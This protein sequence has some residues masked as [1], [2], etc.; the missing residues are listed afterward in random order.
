M[1][2]D[3]TPQP[4]SLIEIFIEKFNLPEMVAGPAGKAIS[5]LIAGGA[6]IPAAYLERFA[7]G[8]RDGTAARTKV[9]SEVAEAAAK[10]A[11]G[12]EG[13][14]A[15]A[16]HTLL[17]KE[18][19]RQKNKEEVARKT[20]EILEEETKLI[21]QK[22]GSNKNSDKRHAEVHDV[23]EDWLNVFER[24]AKDASA[25]NMQKMWAKVL[26]GEIRKPKSFS[27]QTL[28]FLAEVDQ[29][30]AALF[31]KHSSEVINGDFIPYTPKEGKPFTE[32]LQLEEA[33]LLSGTQGFLSR[34]MKTEAPG[35][36][37]IPMRAGTI[38]IVFEQATEF[39]I[40]VAALTKIGRE[41]LQIIPAKMN[42]NKAQEI[43]ARFPKKNVA[44]IL[45]TELRVGGPSEVLWVKEKPP[46]QPKPNG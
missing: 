35:P 15:R 3:L 9:N 6:D 24:Y 25:E 41:V 12:D 40:E 43:A 22:G 1:P 30:T 36:V 37:A 45:L 10:F 42:R 26:A 31:E 33:G 7:Q 18:F 27:L 34:K 21:E 19:R 17:A 16:A 4:S 39:Q 44:T 46:E 32:F 13:I 28:R 11:A 8:I 20:V 14:V 29:A 5:R 2:N 38:F 23:D